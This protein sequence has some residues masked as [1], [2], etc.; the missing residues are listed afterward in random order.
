MTCQEERGATCHPRACESSN[1]K[2]KKSAM[3][4]LMKYLKDTCHMICV[5]DFFRIYHEFL[6]LGFR[7][8]VFLLFRLVGTSKAWSSEETIT[9][10]LFKTQVAP[11]LR[12][13]LGSFDHNKETYQ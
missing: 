7:A 6:F 4:Q 1:R 8:S 9:D 11:E 3:C 13:S 2:L 5:R 12:R 10:F